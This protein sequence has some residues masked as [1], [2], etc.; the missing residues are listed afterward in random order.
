MKYIEATIEDY[1][2]AYRLVNH[3]PIDTG[4]D[5]MPE[6]SALLFAELKRAGFDSPT[7]FTRLQITLKCPEWTTKRVRTWIDPLVDA[8]LLS[9][10][11]G[12]KNRR[13]YVFTEIGRQIS[14]SKLSQNCFRT[15]SAP[16]VLLAHVCPNG[17]ASTTITLQ[18]N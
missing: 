11:T 8:D 3:A 10:R 1:A 16:E 7:P 5:L 2:E 15:L 14:P 4:T 13:E 9:V 17:R 18:G 12:L 6:E